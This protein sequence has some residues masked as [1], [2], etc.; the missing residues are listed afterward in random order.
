MTRNILRDA[1][2]ATK[3]VFKDAGHVFTVRIIPEDAGIDA[4]RNLGRMMID[5]MTDNEDATIELF[6]E[7]RDGQMIAEV[8]A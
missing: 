2:P 8:G 3:V 6:G 5:W 1:V 7:S 4:S